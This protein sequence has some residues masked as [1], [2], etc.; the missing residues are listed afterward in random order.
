VTATTLLPSW[1]RDDLVAAAAGRLQDA[2]LS[3]RPCAPVRDLIDDDAELVYAVQRR[4]TAARVLDGHKV[5]G[6]KIGLTS[7]AVQKQLGVD[8]Q[9]FGFSL[10]TWPVRRSGSSTGTDPAV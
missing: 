7:A 4:L 9:D 2:A 1:P 8:R 3:R 6:R 5:I 10:P